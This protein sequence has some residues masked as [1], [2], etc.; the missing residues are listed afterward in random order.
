[1]KKFKWLLVLAMFAVVLV[2]AATF[3]QDYVTA[4]N[5]ANSS[6]ASVDAGTVMFIICRIALLIN[7][8]IPVAISLGALLFIWGVVSYVIA[9]D[10]EAKKRG[11]N[12]IIWGLAGLAV[13]VS[14]WALIAILKR[15][16]GIGDEA[17]IQVVCVE[18]PG[19]KCPN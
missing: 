8:L 14:V 16:L 7:T 3:A 19:I 6:C 5:T 13:I 12:L 1:M 15:T 4:D 17:A 9:K 18:S 10:E 11:K 2:P